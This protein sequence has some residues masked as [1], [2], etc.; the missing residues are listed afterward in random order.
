MAKAPIQTPEQIKAILQ[1][2]SSQSDRGA[3]IVAAAAI[4]ELTEQVILER[5]IK[6][7]S[8]RT[9]AL[10][11]RMNA[12]LSSFAAKIEIAFA[13]GIIANELRLTLHFIRDVRNKFAHRIES[14]TFDHPEIAAIIEKRMAERVAAKK[15]SNRDKYMEVFHAASVILIGTRGAEMRIKPLEETHADHFLR[16]FAEAVRV[17]QGEAES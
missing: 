5:F 1:E 11:R 2:V 3:A 10:F 7:S 15:K 14:L 6:L 9:E 13:I 17:A 4:E 12:P 8:D 16:F